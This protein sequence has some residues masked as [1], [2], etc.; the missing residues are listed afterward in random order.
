MSLAGSQTFV[1]P[2]VPSLWL[3]YATYLNAG[4]IF[5]NRTNKRV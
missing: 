1:N 5:N 3:T 4:I 2:D